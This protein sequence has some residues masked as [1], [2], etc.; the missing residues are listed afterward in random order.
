MKY[1]II[2]GGIC[3]TTA[4]EVIRSRD[5][6]AS[7]A[8]VGAEFFP[9]YSRIMLSKPPYF[10]GQIPADK[11]WI[12]QPEWYGQNKIKAYFGRAAIGLDPQKKSVRLDDGTVLEYDKLLLALGTLPRK[13]ELPGGNLKG[14]YYLKSLLDSESIRKALPKINEAVLVGGGAISLEACELMRLSGKKT[15]LV[16]REHHYWDPLLDDEA[17][18]LVEAALLKG[19]VRLLKERLP[20]EIKGERHVAGLV[21]DDGQALSCQAVIFGIGCYTPH[22]W[23]KTSQ[24]KLRRGIVTN[25]FLETSL[26]DVWA[27]GDCAEYQDVIL[28]EIMQNGSYG[29]ALSQGRVAAQNMLGEKQAFHMVATYTVTAFGMNLSFLGDPRPAEGIAVI[30]RG[31]AADGSY[32]RLLLKDNKL[33]GATLVN[34]VAE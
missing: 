8:L 1:V 14:V 6:N 27:A 3:G 26:P 32:A 23:L 24:I 30:R 4:A 19:G 20:K 13:T 22:D 28:G 31:Q 9:L 29:S 25:E 7:V 15:T 34:R 16:I 17:A 21:L 11:I 12:K 18:S 5:P 2:G 33:V 10:L